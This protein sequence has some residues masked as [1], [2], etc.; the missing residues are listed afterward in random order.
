MKVKSSY[1]LVGLMSLSLF[2][3]AS[4]EPT[5][6]D[7]GLPPGT[8]WIDEKTAMVPTGGLDDD[9][10]QAYRMHAPGQM[11]AQ[12]VYYQRADGTFSANKMEAACMTAS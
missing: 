7:G 6:S 11:V 2:A 4:E 12:V 9:G 1:L 5:T 3:C 10:C 8:V